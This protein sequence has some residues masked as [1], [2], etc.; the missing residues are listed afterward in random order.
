MSENRLRSLVEFTSKIFQNGIV[1]VIA[2]HFLSLICNG[3]KMQKD[4]KTPMMGLSFHRKS[5]EFLD[6]HRRPPFLGYAP[7][8]VGCLE[9]TFISQGHRRRDEWKIDRNSLIFGG[10]K[11]LV[12]CRCSYWTTNSSCI[13]LCDLLRGKLDLGGQIIVTSFDQ[14]S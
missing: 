5:L 13:L 10:V 1:V 4:S 2:T 11:H 8:Q 12:S 14:A 7:Q 6:F 3:K 9:C